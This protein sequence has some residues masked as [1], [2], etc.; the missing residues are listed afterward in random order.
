M[1]L[2]A[3]VEGLQQTQKAGCG[4][5]IRLFGFKPCDDAGLDDQYSFGG[6]VWLRSRLWWRFTAAA[7]LRLRS[8][9]GFS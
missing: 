2:A 1:S 4:R 3:A 5:R 8:A 7:S 6:R 9:V